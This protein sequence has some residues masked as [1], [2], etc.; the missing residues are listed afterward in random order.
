MSKMT[1]KEKIGQL[2]QLSYSEQA[3]DENTSNQIA[4]G[5]IGSFLN[6]YDVNISNA[7]QKVAMEKS[8]LKIPLLIGKD[9]I[10]G[11]RTIFPIPLGQAATFNP[12]IVEEGAR[13]AAIEGSAIGVRW[14][15]S[16]M[17]DIARDPRWG[18]IA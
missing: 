6:L 17:L 18:R 9:I 13:V 10:H 3:L 7:V 11:S 15:F 4:N 14:T 5:M 8:R 2:I 1:L 12:D 16:P